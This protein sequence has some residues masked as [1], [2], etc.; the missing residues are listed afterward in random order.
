MPVRTEPGVAYLSQEGLDVIMT[1]I[2][3]NCYNVATHKATEEMFV[4]CQP[5]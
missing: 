2:M 3:A 1:Y 5:K 4:V